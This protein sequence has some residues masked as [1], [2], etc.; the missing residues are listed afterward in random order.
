MSRSFALAGAAVLLTLAVGGAW[1]T[2]QQ[3]ERRT[4]ANVGESLRIVAKTTHESLQEW[5]EGEREYAERLFRHPRIS[6]LTQ[7][8]LSGPRTRS[9]LL[10][11]DAFGAL[12]TH[13]DGIIETHGEIGV[14]VISPDL[15]NIFSLRDENVGMR[16]LI[17]DQRPDQLRRAFSGETVFVPPIRSDVSL[18]DAAGGT[19]EGAPTMF[20]AVP[21]ESDGGE[22]I[23]VATLRFDPAGDL[24]HLLQV[25][26][27][28]RSGETYAFD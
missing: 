9:A 17:S 24:T 2:L 26:R 5:F 7:R 19:V 3:I 16:S 1:I 13:F 4:R 22:V 11:N 18:P 10:S 21:L 8:L 20:L 14:F 28:G 6:R 23:A 12:R 25:A 27:M 15:V